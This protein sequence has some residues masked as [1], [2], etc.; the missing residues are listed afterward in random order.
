MKET[1][2]GTLLGAIVGA[3][4]GSVLIIINEWVKI[5]SD[6]KKEKNKFDIWNALKQTDYAPPTLNDNRLSGIT[7]IDIKEISSLLYEMVK[8]GTISEVPSSGFTR[9]KKNNR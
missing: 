8:E 7:K 5:R 3:I 9:Y 6:N 1:I 2:C 4:V